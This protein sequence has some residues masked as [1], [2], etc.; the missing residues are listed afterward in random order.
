MRILTE[1]LE[2]TSWSEE[3]AEAFFDLTQ[4][5]GFNLYPITVYRQKSPDAAR[6]WLRES[7]ALRAQ[8]GFGKVAIWERN[9][10][11][12][13]GMGGLTPWTWEGERLVDLTYRLRESSW[14]RGYGKEAAVALLRHG[15]EDRGLSQITATITPDN[16]A[17]RKIANALG[18]AFDRSIVLKGV[19]TD[20]FRLK[21][22]L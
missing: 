19:A 5:N 4:D 15:F 6:Q 2:L 1:R 21:K 16:L 18:M 17:S 7:M 13:V 3:H 9:S 8:T 10:D 11:R 20:L 14:G 22:T 12:L